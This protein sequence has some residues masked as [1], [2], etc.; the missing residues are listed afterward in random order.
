MVRKG[1]E[2]LSLTGCGPHSLHLR[3]ADQV[4]K[5]T[6][7]SK[8]LLR[9]LPHLLPIQVVLLIKQA[10][11]V[12]QGDGFNTKLMCRLE[13]FIPRIICTPTNTIPFLGLEEYVWGTT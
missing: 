9:G 12:L 4:E 3:G 8:T 5:A 11:S 6:K 13:F 10:I 2:D 7:R 1:A